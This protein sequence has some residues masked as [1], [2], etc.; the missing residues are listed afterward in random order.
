[1][2]YMGTPKV[3]DPQ[4]EN[5]SSSEALATE[6]CTASTLV[7]LIFGTSRIVS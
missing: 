6:D 1:M 4:G 2:V 7:N 5:T 3:I